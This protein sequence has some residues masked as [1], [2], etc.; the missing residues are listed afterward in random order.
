MIYLLMILGLLSAQV[1][2]PSAVVK[3]I[4]LF[5]NEVQLGVRGSSSIRVGSKFAAQTAVKHK[6]LLVVTKVIRNLAY[7][8]ANYCPGY[9]TLKKGQVV[10]LAPEDEVN[11]E[12]Q[13][14][15]IQNT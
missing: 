13:A 10:T 3:S 6:C 15:P 14:S 9:A 11:E 8:D 12:V 4:S 2:T 7:A 5:R 1:E